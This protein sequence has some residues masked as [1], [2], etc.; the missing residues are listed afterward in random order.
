MTGA[1]RMNLENPVIAHRSRRHVLATGVAAFALFTGLAWPSPATTKGATMSDKRVQTYD[2]Y[3]AAWSAVSDNERARML[4]ESVADDVVFENPQ[5]TRHGRADLKAHLEGFQRRSPGGA[6]RMNHMVGW[7]GHA[8]AEWQLVD[9]NGHPGFSGVDVLTFDDQG[10]IATILLFGNVE[11]QKLAWRRRD[12][13]S[14]Q[15]TP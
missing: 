5:Q 11:A 2:L 14:L 3:L 6:F 12:P 4:G 9:A 1:F 10:R 15:P 13:V 7:D 8:L